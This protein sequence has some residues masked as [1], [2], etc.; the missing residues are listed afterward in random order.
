MTTASE[1]LSA[2]SG[3]IR[4]LRVSAISAVAVIL[5]AAGHEIGGGA[6]APGATLVSVFAVIFAVSWFLTSR[7]LTLGQIAGLL[8]IAQLVV[9]LSCMGSDMAPMGAAMIGGH[10]AATALTALIVSRGELFLWSLADRLGL[11]VVALVIFRVL[12]PV[13]RAAHP[14]ISNERRRSLSYVFAGG[15]GL[16]GPP[17]DCV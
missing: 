7:R 6:V 14:V 12:R 11:R 4:L 9:H 1:A 13:G 15:P 17:I 3:P 5:A 2:R 16:R 8:L 10:L